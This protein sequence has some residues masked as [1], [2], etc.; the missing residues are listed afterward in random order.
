MTL[1]SESDLR[2]IVET[3]ATRRSDHDHIIELARDKPDFLEVMLEDEKLFWRVIGDEDVLIRISPPLLFD[4]LLRRALKDIERQTYTL[5]RVGATDRIPVFDSERV[6]GLMKD[7]QLRDYLRDMLAS[8]TRTQS[9]TVYFKSGKA[10]YRRTYSDMDVD[11]MIA[12]AGLVDEEFRFPFYKRIG[13]ICLFIAGIFWEHIAARTPCQLTIRPRVA[14][15]KQR[16]LEDYEQD[17]SRFYHRAAE[18]TSARKTNLESI[19]VTLADNFTLA[20]KPLNLISDKY[21]RLQ[22]AKWF[23]PLKEVS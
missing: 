8:F 5:E 4:I 9:A 22:K 21:I 18:Q 3:V 23:A 12:I 2:F 7:R 10:Y 13:D 15:R 17:A 14:G 6:V 1:M 16:S 19:L 11:D 20:K